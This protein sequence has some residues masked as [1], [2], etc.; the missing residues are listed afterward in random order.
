MNKKSNKSYLLNYTEDTDKKIN[1]IIAK[2]ALVKEQKSER[3]SDL[4]RNL[5]EEEFEK[6]NFKQND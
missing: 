4:F 5:V 1:F 2:R 6:L 3:L